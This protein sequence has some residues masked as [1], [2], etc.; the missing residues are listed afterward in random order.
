[1]TAAER[2]GRAAGRR[3]H[4][5]CMMAG[6]ALTL[7]ACPYNGAMLQHE[8]WAGFWSRCSRAEAER[9]ALRAHSAKD[10]Y[11]D[12]CFKVTGPIQ[13]AHVEHVK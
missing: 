12:R 2:K 5:E 7:P 10:L 4:R 1:M 11:V 3:Y 8:W 9:L 6:Q 13:V